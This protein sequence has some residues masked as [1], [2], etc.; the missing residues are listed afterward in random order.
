M[1]AS[2]EVN[3]KLISHAFANLRDH[4]WV[5]AMEMKNLNALLTEAQGCADLINFPDDLQ[6]I[7]KQYRESGDE[8]TFAM[9][10]G[11][12]LLDKLNQAV[13]YAADKKS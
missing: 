12:L 4:F 9:V 13:I 7:V 2:A 6:K 11:A 10:E 8:V 5:M 3:G 1:S